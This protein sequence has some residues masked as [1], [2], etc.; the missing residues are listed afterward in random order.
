[1]KEGTTNLFLILAICVALVVMGLFTF[2]K[3]V[4]D[5]ISINVT[6]VVNAT[7]SSIV[8]FHLQCLEN[9]NNHFFDSW[10]KLNICYD[11]CENI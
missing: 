7:N 3:P 2:L 10:D 9:C 6:G 11:A 1:M 8:S 5:S 4:P